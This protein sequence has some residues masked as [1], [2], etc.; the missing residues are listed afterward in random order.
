LQSRRKFHITKRWM[1][2]NMTNKVLEPKDISCIPI[3]DGTNYGHWH[4]R[5]K[6]HLRSKDLIYV[7]EKPVPGGA[8]TSI[9]NE[10]SRASYESINLITTRITE[11]VFREVV[12]TETIEKANLLWAKIEDQYAS[13]RAL[14]RGRVWMD[15]ERCFYDGNLQS[16]IDLCRKLIMELEAVSI[17]VPQELLSYSLL[18]KLGGETNLHQ[19]VE[20]LT[21]NEDIIDKP[22]KILTRL[23]D[24]AHLNNVDC[25]TQSTTQTALISSGGE[26]H[27]VIYYCEKGRHND[28]CSTHK[29][30]DCCT[31]NPHLRPP[32]REKKRRHFNPTAHFT[33]AQALTTYPR[34]QQ[35]SSRQLIIDCGA[36]HHMFND[37]QLFSSDLRPASIKV[38]TGDVNSNLTAL[39][40][41]T[42]KI[43]SNNKILTF[44]NFLYV[45]PLKCNLISLLELFKE[46]LTVNQK[47]NTFKLVSQ[48]KEILRG[49]IINKLMTSTYSVPTSL[50]TSSDKT[51]W[52]DRLSHPGPAVLKFLGISTNKNNS[53]IC[54]VNKSHKQSFNNH[55]EPALNVLDCVH[56][57]IVGPVT[58]PSVSE[59]FTNLCSAKKAM[60]N[61][62]NRTL[63][64]LVTDRG[65]EF[66]N[67]NFR[68]LAENCGYAHIMALP[69]MPQHNGF[70]ERA[71]RT[72]LEKTC[73]LMSQAN[74]PKNYWADAVSTAVS[75]SNLS[76][77]ASRKN[78]SPH[79]LRTN[80]PPKLKRLR[81]FGCREVIHNLKR[82]YKGK[83]EPPRQPGILIG[84]DNNNTAY[85]IVRLS[86]SKVAVTHHV[87]FN[88]N[89]FPVLPSGIG[90]RH[91]IPLDFNIT[92]SQKH[93]EI[94]TETTEICEQTV[95]TQN[96][97]ESNN[98]ALPA[99]QPRIKIIGPR[100]PTIISSQINN[101][102]ILPYKRRTNALLTTINEALNTYSKAIKSKDNS[103]WQEA[104]NN[105]LTNMETL[106]VW[107]VVEL[108][109][110]YKIA[111]TTWVF[112]I[113]RKEL[114]EPI[115]YKAQLCAQG[116]TQSVGIDFDKIYAPTGQLNYL[117]TLIAFACINNLQF[118]QI[119]IKCAFLN[120]PLKETVYLA[121]PQG[122]NLEK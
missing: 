39:G 1:Q 109:D 93:N 111:G 33:M 19:F 50:L 47:D 100:H 118:H 30:E 64:R 70:A 26:P 38:A 12:N 95:P 29:K 32:R 90:N 75:L 119:D 44:K 42:V 3:L 35:P 17:V 56:M 87:T 79:F 97:E 52:H 105:E 115:E 83:M 40:I 92:T 15:W 121:I 34:Q 73:C 98:E 82:Q 106:R 68:K 85:C 23:Q 36:T 46:E 89:M 51:P 16:Y 120:A 71:N 2:D 60:E 54:E 114:N 80:T 81:I 108:Q 61:L 96:I 84:Y 27:K 103:L 14:N 58:P 76:P 21:L 104:I 25:K 107:D 113:K 66:A 77:T 102:N 86:S 91:S 5:M 43:I 122:F 4:M 74:L 6:I 65:G 48:G 67:H 28:K 116:F 31:K 37:S 9:V 45:P 22:E 10:W 99:Q 53:L 62:Q 101:I 20:N 49:K 59:V 13:K 112:K 7:C 78:Q 94:E 63:K 72:I 8:S 117:R 69:E 24:L 18:G 11:R 110:D 88:E 55:F 41:G 57:D